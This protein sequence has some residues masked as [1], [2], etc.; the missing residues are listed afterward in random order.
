MQRY[1][2]YD[3]FA[4]L[5]ATHWGGEY[6]DQAW[7]VLDK[8]ILHQLPRGAAVLDLCC[9]DGRL[10]GVLDSQGYR[11]TGLDGSERMLEFARERCPHVPF[12]AGDAREFRFEQGFDAIISTFDAL[13]HVMTPDGFAS[14][15]RSVH[16][17]LKPGGYFA[18]DLN[19]EEA[20]TELWAQTST[21]IEPDMVSVAVGSY[22]RAT[23]VADCRITLFRLFVDRWVRSDFMLSEFCHRGEDV[24]NS[25]YAA[26]FADAEEFD[27]C[28][29]LGMVGNIGKGRSYYLGR[30]GI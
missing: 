12:V 26:G 23:R 18:F 13:N 2:D 6:H 8:L 1:T 20:Y 21:Q 14:V 19:R 28:T 4:W 25:L 22:N 29:D 3:P 11:V 5:Y 30:R 9:G 7:A 16:R 10:A 27:A 15:C 24:M 17:A